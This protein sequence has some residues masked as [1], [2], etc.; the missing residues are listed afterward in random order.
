M[1]LL[2]KAFELLFHEVLFYGFYFYDSGVTCKLHKVVL[3][4]RSGNARAISKYKP[5]Y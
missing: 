1:F 4:T 3:M 5:S 2:S